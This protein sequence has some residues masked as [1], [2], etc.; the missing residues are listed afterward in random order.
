MSVLPTTF[1]VNETIIINSITGAD[2]LR[3]PLD[4]GGG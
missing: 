3:T 2:A 4:R 1:F